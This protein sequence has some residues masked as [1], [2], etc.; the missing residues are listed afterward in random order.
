MHR[1]AFVLT[2]VNQIS[3]PVRGQSLS[4][5]FVLHQRTDTSLVLARLP[6]LT[7][8]LASTTR[9]Q[10][11]IPGNRPQLTP[12]C[13]V[14]HSDDFVVG[15]WVREARAVCAACRASTPPYSLT[16][17]HARVRSLRFQRETFPSSA[18]ADI[19]TLF[20]SPIFYSFLLSIGPTQT[21]GGLYPPEVFTIF[22]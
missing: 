2:Q 12:C 10:V 22:V 11:V 18:L 14:L 19:S 13:S 7:V 9:K 15:A 17:R 1:L 3:C 8:Y 5:V 6:W 16:P 4:V 20:F 21:A